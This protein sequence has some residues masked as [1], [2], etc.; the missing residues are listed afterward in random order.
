[1]SDSPTLTAERTP[2]AGVEEPVDAARGGVERVD[3]AAPAADEDAAAGD[4]WPA[5]RTADRPE[6]RTP[7]SASAAERPPRSGLPLPHPGNVCWT[8][9]VPSRSSAALSLNRMRRGSRGHIARWR[10]RGARRRF[11]SD[12]PVRNSAMA[13]RSAAVRSVAIVIIEPVSI[14]AST[15]SAGIDRNASRAGARFDAGVVALRAGPLVELGAVRCLCVHERRK[16]EHDHTGN[17]NSRNRL[18]HGGG[19]IRREKR[20]LPNSNSQRNPEPGTRNDWELDSWELG[21]D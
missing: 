17:D 11:E 6:T 16:S 21:I 19:I 15:R 2:C 8:C 12:L 13:R 5:S 4:A 18:C 10:G 7:I 20:Q 1:M 3:L 14:A 9:S